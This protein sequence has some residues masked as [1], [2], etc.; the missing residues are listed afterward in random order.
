M[1]DQLHSPLLTWSKAVA[2]E[3]EWV[4]LPIHYGDPIGEQW[5]LAESRAFTDLSTL[6]AVCV[7]GPDRQSWLTNMTSQIINGMTP[8][9]SKELLV[10][11]ANGRIEHAAAVHD[12]GETTWLVTVR[13]RVDAL[14]QWLESMKF[15]LRVEVA[16]RHGIRVIGTVS[17]DAQTDPLAKTARN[18]PGYLFTWDDPWP[19]VV[20]GGTR[21]FAGS[22]HPGSDTRFHLHIVEGDGAITDMMSSAGDSAGMTP[23]GMLA[24][25]ALR[26]AAWRPLI[27]RDTDA[28]SIP[29]ELDWMRTAVHLHKGC[30]RGQ[31]SVARVVN[32]GKPPRRLTFLQLDGSR[33]D[34][35]ESGARLMRGNRQVGV[36]TSAAR[37]Y[38]LG[39]VALA[40]IS[41][42]VPEDTVFDIDGVSAAQEIIVPRDGRSEDSPDE[43]PGKDLTNKDLR[44]LDIPPAGSP[45]MSGGRKA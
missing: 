9:E 44:R 8:A 4:G 5:A 20:E 23:A 40:L 33:G 11:D 22:K 31:E 34:L 36:V 17:S 24:W 29:A 32:L 13:D 15:M 7:S 1:T 38:E 30:Y 35:P 26:I 41:R 16:E 28:R 25:D 43:R 2:G 39:P 10:L 18:L 3:G 12:D 19:G 6:A 27:G 42:N 37:H 21:Y 14:A 45:H